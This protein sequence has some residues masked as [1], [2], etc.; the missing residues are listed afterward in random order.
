MARMNRALSPLAL[1]VGLSMA[2]LL[3]ACGERTEAEM[4]SAARAAVDKQD[5]SAAALE[6]KN[7]LQAYPGSGEARWLLGKLLLDGGDPA[8][9]E[10]ELQRALDAGQRPE[11]V[12]PVLATA[13]VALENY[14]G[15]VQRFDTTELQ[16]PRASAELRAQLA[17][18]H[19]ALGDLDRADSA[20]TAALQ[21]V[22][23]HPG[24]RVLQARLSAARGDSTKALAQLA[25][26]LTRTPGDALAWQARGEI[27]AG[28]GPAGTA[29]ALEAYRKALGLKPD[30]IAAHAALVST[31]LAQQDFD[32]AAKQ[33]GALKAARPNHPQTLFFEAMLAL[34]RGRAQEA[35]DICQL[36]LRRVPNNPRLLMLSAQ[37]ELQLNAFEQAETLAAKAVQAAP[38]AVSP[39]R[40]LAEVQLRTGQSTKALATLRPLGEAQASDAEVLA[41]VGRAQFMAGDTRAAEATLARAARLKPDDSR[42]RTSA[43]L[44]RLGKGS[45]D[46]DVDALAALARTESDSAADLLLVTARLQRKEFDGALKAVDALARKLPKQAMPDYLRGR[47]ELERGGTALARKHFEQALAV[48][49]GYF[50]AIARLS[51]LDL[52]DGKPEAAR[53]RFEALAQRE[54]GNAPVRMALA[55]LA[56]RTGANRATVTALLEAAVKAS[57]SDVASRAALVDQLL[58][59]SDNKA[60]LAAAQ[61]AVTAIPDSA[62]LVERLGR[63]QLA[64]RDVNQTIAAFT[65]LA[66]MQPKSALPQLWL[67]EAYLAKQDVA[68]ANASARRALALEP[69]TLPAQRAAAMAALRDKQPAQALA[70]ARAVQ[71]QRPDDPAGWL[72]EGDIESNQQHFD[73]AATAFRRALGKPNA[74]LAAVRLHTALISAGKGDEADRFAGTWRQAHPDDAA[75]IFQLGDAAMHRGDL[76]AA[77]AHYR[78]VVKRQPGNFMALN[79]IAYLLIR[80]KKAGAVEVAERAVKLR[81]E[82]PALLDTLAMGYAQEQQLDKALELQARVV[83]MAPESADFRMNLARLHLQAGDKDKARLELDR[84]ARLGR[85]FSGHE[86]V[87]QLLKRL[88]S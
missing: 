9:A 39:R 42:I 44:A 22:P 51:A 80:Q 11:Q 49:P 62:D 16:D 52:A 15:L 43:A 23:D 55:E 1:A 47:I 27:L 17:A 20:L 32:A 70:I 57:P 77:E 58:A 60:A 82:Q 65:K 85:S 87:A 6:L 76:A 45:V 84:L 12:V 75:F 28:T 37:V 38:K 78:E 64:S 5:P 31:L 34:Q 81:P 30:L 67:A 79:N 36:L 68:A 13:L 4:L 8:G 74:A 63:V 2:L 48:E 46:A 73:A 86:E 14:A 59:G 29:P 50:P 18:A 41:L 83:S 40:L 61:S 26:W 24:A 66:G 71:V 56:A 54:P 72:L 35:R 10:A 53:A 33:L 19:L 69:K 25:E 21:R 88:D 3:A 7:L